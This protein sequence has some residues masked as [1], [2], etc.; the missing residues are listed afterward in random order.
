MCVKPALCAN[1]Y[2]GYRCVCNGTTDV[3]ETQSCV[4]GESILQ[5]DVFQLIDWLA[6]RPGCEENSSARTNLVCTFQLLQTESRRMISSWSWFW[7]WS[8]ALASLCF[9]SCCWLLWLVSAAARRE[10]LESEY[11]PVGVQEG[12]MLIVDPYSVFVVIRQ[13]PFQGHVKWLYLT[14]KWQKLAQWDAQQMPLHKKHKNISRRRQQRV[15]W[16]SS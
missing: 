4:L 9:C 13:G 5:L 7:A 2:G 8:W 3:D 16:T 10:S 6:E 15:G 12:G 14:P 11:C 1:T